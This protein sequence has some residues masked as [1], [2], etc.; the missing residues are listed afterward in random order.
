MS[1]VNEHS[2]GINRKPEARFNFWVNRILGNLW[3][4]TQWTNYL[5][6]FEKINELA[7]ELQHGTITPGRLLRNVWIRGGGWL[8]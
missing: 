3:Y 5:W 8:R 2:D 1:I 6:P 4:S 7:S